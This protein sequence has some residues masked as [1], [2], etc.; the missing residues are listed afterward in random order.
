MANPL[1]LFPARVPI[2]RAT[3]PDGRTVDVLMTPEFA[4]ALS[5][6]LDRVGGPSSIGLADLVELL[7]AESTDTA[8][9][10]ALR[11]VTE[12]AKQ[13]A[14]AESSAAKISALERRIEDLARLVNSAGP[15]PVDWE[16]P[17]KIGAG[18]SN[19]GKFTAATVQTLNKLTFTQPAT[20][21]TYT[22]A[23]GKTFTVSNTLT[24][25]ATDG[26]TLNIGGGGTLGSA[27]YQ[28]ST[29]FAARSGATLFAAATDPATT[30]SL[31]N[32]LRNVL[33][34]VGIGT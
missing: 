4:R 17:G 10:S 11:A 28:A 14:A 2:G 27:A 6:L 34:S 24:L 16:H 1:N 26:A 5:D 32:Q 33:I 7:A 29:A 30:Q 20:A 21:A 31:V 23:D 25:T 19:T 3:G 8:G 12:L 15:A 13:L 18:K 22:L 9:A